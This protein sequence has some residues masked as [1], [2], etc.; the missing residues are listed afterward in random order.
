M[1]YL[2]RHPRGCL[3]QLKLQINCFFRIEEKE[4]YYS[5]IIKELERMGVLTVK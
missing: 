4:V 2:F 3:A 1:I 5:E